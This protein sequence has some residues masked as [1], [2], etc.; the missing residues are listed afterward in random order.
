MDSGHTNVLW[1][2]LMRDRD[3]CSLA[4]P[5]IGSRETVVHNCTQFEHVALDPAY[6]CL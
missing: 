2:L 6:S 5:P 3:R 1:K 4:A